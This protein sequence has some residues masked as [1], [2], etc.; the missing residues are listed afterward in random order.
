MKLQLSFVLMLLL[1][2]GGVTAGCFGRS[3]RAPAKSITS[4]KVTY[5][6]T[7]LQFGEI[8]FIPQV[9]PPVQAPI[10]N[11]V[12]QVSY[13]GGVAVGIARVEIDG[14]RKTGK[15]IPI[16]PEETVSTFVQF[17]PEKYNSRT[18]LSVEITGDRDNTHDFILD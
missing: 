17:L 14:F 1:S 18:T 6:N 11:G 3:G 7:P 16:S 13:K 10:E 9:G 8:R 2:I 15:E 5:Q 4:G 12:Y